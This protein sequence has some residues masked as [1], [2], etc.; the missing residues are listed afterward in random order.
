MMDKY[1]NYMNNELL[2]TLTE[3]QKVKEEWL[4]L[5]KALVERLTNDGAEPIDKR[6]FLAS[7]PIEMAKP[8]IEYINSSR[9]MKPV[10]ERRK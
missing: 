3:A 4:A 7:M 6:E 1:T 10:K 8:L 2:D 5:I 9:I